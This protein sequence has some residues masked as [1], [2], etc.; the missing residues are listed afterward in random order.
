MDAKKLIVCEVCSKS[1]GDGVKL[2]VC[3][4]CKSSSYCSKV[5]IIHLSEILTDFQ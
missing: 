5:N 2:L 3:S 4:S 1:D